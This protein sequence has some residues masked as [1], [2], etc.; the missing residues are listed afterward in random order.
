MALTF[1]QKFPLLNKAPEFNLLDVS[2]GNY[3]SY[4]DLG[5]GMVTVVMFICNHCP[6]VKYIQSQLV[7]VANIYI[8]EGVS[9]IAINSND[10]DS[11]PDDSP[12]KMKDVAQEFDYPFPYLYDETQKVAKA[13]KAACTPDF[14]IFN[15]DSE[16]I[17]HGCFDL[18]NHKNNMPSTGE[19]L[20]LALDLAIEGKII[21]EE[22]QKPSSGCNIKWKSGISPF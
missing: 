20:K 4:K 14:Y 16:C 3:Y 12:E 15:E 2:T 8:S 9:F 11:F 6:Y 5:A 22:L 1:S 13:Y 17:Y 21:K 18:S 19:N 7:R 10:A